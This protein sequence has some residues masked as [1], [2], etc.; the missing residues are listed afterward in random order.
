M[1]AQGFSFVFI[2]CTAIHRMRIHRIRVSLAS[3][4]PVSSYPFG[5]DDFYP[6]NPKGPGPQNGGPGFLRLLPQALAGSEY[7]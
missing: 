1:E 5:Y 4:L 3:N 7:K 2:Y 6:G